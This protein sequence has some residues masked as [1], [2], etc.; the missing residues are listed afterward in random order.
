MKKYGLYAFH[1]LL[2]LLVVQV[3]WV[4]IWNYFFFL[5]SMVAL[6]IPWLLYPEYFERRNYQYNS[7]ILLPL[8][9]TLSIV[10]SRFFHLIV[11]YIAKPGINRITIPVALLFYALPSFIFNEY[12]EM[13][14][15]Y[16]NKLNARRI[17]IDIVIILVVLLMVYI[18]YNTLPWP[19]NWAP[20]I[21]Q[22]ES[23]EVCSAIVQN[24]A[25]PGYSIF[26]G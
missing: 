24:I 5:F 7:Y 13:R 2:L 18:F 14:R 9:F 20:C 25:E 10:F 6:L 15:E 4:L 11:L 1:L 12:W 21:L 26:P 16:I 22:D 19:V 23:A 17:F 3:V 8:T